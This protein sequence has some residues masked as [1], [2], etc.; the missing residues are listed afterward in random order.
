M[1]TRS[2]KEQVDFLQ[3]NINKL[4]LNDRNFAG[5]V[6]EGANAKIRRIGFATEKQRACI[7]KLV[8]RIETPVPVENE[9]VKTEVGNLARLLEMFDKAQDN[10][11][12]PAINIEL[13]GRSIKLTLASS[14]APVP[15]SI[16]VVEDNKWWYGRI[17]RDGK[18]EASPRY[19][20][21]DGLVDSLIEFA[22]DPAR[23]ASEH[24]RKTGNCCFCSRDL[25][26]K[27]STLVGYG[28]ICATRFGL[29]W[30]EVV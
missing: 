25:T 20:T 16:Y 2:D 11:K 9:R 30:G 29:P 24:G 18:F 5:C 26:D 7:D 23:I 27:R 13:A 22:S 12:N 28:P 8:A 21:P 3:T 15:G 1:I 6:V 4:P 19:P 17:L 10:I 14:T